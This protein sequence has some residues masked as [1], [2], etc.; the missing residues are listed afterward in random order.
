MASFDR[1]AGIIVAGVVAIG[2]LSAVPARAKTVLDP[3]LWQDT[4]TGTENGK[5]VKPKVTTDCMSKK[6]A[7]YP[8]KALSEMKSSAGQQCSKVE[9]NHADSGFSIVMHC[10][11]P[12][13]FAMDMAATFTIQ[14]RRHYSG[15]VKTTVVFSGRKMTGEKRIASKWIAASC[16]K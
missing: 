6:D 16:K 7:A 11:D 9:V 14:D 8:A 1:L 12:K 15:L 5:P 3:G 4:E 13:R 2:L 10:G